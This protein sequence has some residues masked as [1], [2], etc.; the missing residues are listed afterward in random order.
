V[1]TLSPQGTVIIENG[2]TCIQVDNEVTIKNNF[3]VKV[4][5]EFEIKV[6]Q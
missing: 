6:P 3:E 4:G 1:T 5:A 2:K